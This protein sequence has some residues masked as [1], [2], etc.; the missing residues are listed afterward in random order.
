MATGRPSKLTEEII[1]QAADAIKRVYYVEIA[2]DLMGIHRD[3]FYEWLKRGE[4]EGEPNPLYGI[5]SDTIKKARAE[6]KLSLL[7]EVRSG[8]AGE[9]QA[10]GWILERCYPS[11]FGL[12]Q[13]IKL[14][15]DVD[16]TTS[17]EELAAKAKALLD[18]MGK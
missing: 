16:T 12:R 18:S 2:A 3:T 7:A 15:V 5:F 14:D 10:K 17:A 8:K 13:E 4:S 11:E 6:A 1:Q 9:W